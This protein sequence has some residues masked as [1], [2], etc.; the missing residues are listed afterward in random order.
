MEEMPVQ[1]LIQ[2]LRALG[3][4]PLYIFMLDESLQEVSNISSA[5]NRSRVLAQM[6]EQ[7]FD[8]GLE[9]L[10]GYI[11]RKSLGSSEEIKKKLDR[12][13]TLG[14]TA[15]YVY[16]YERELAEDIL[17]KAL[18]TA[19]EISD[20]SEKIR[21]FAFVAEV[22]TTC[23]LEEEAKRDCEEVLQEALDLAEREDDVLPLTRLLEVL[24]DVS[25]DRE[26]QD[27][28]ERASEF[29]DELSNENDKNW[30]LARISIAL[31][32]AGLLKKAD[33]IAER[34]C[35]EGEGLPIGEVMIAL[36]E[37]DEVEKALSFQ[38]CI[39]SQLLKDS[40]LSEMVSVLAEKG[41]VSKAL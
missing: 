14:D 3:E 37:A 9:E 4:K 36:T 26:I 30:M 2:R 29:A 40:I 11:C 39:S 18:N 35:S 32:K 8:S 13:K 21:A 5:E 17:G 7:F 6:S 23:G 15:L 33:Q 22:R 1:E 31:V 24:A 34:L 25:S 10:G 12:V 41:D 38:R 20:C 19:R 16:E 28:C 27:L